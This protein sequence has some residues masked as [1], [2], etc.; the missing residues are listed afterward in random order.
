[1]KSATYINEDSSGFKW[2]ADLFC[3]IS[4]SGGLLYILVCSV[5]CL[6]AQKVVKKSLVNSKTSFIQIDTQNCFEVLVRSVDTQEVT[7]EGTIDGEYN[8]HLVIRI[9]EEGA[10]V[11]VS[12]GFSPNFQVP[13]DKLSAHKVISIRLQITLPTFKNV[14]IYGASSNVSVEGSFA[15]LKVVLNDGMCT[16]KDISE[17]VEVTTLSGD[18]QIT[19][20]RG[21]INAATDYGTI[22][23]DSAVSGNNLIRLHSISGNIKIGKTR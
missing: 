10:T 6:Q 21:E 4:K 16:L 17:I 14:H 19:A 8:E 22:Y 15:N 2:L 1:M 18:I 23:K 7:V 12:A 3:L 20:S 13:N 11:Q 9:E 5:Y